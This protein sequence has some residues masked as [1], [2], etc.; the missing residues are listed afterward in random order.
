MHGAAIDQAAM[1]EACAADAGQDVRKTGMNSKPLRILL[2]APGSNPNSVTG[3]LIGFSHGNALARVH[4]VT[5]VIEARD[6]AAVLKAEGAF[7]RVEAIPPSW[8]DRFYAWAFRRVFKR[9]RGNLLFTALSFP[10][11]L[12][13]EW[14]AWRQLKKRIWQGEFDVVLRILPI[15]PMYASPFAYFLRKGP[16][17]F[18]I[19]PLNGGLPWPK[20]FSQLDRQRAAAGNWAA[21]M[22]HLYGLLPFARSTFAKA[23]AII[24]GSSHTCGEFAQY[25]EKVFYVPGENGVNASWIEERPLAGSESTSNIE[26]IYVGRLVPYKACDLALRGAAA[27]LRSGRAH[28]SILGD[29]PER[30]RFEKL[31][32]EL[33]ISAAVTFCGMATHAETLARLGRS[34]VLIFPSLREFGGG[35]VFEALAKG[36]VPIVA[37]YGGPGDIVTDQVGYRIPLTDESRMAAE[38]ESVLERLASD[39]DH[40]ETLRRR[41]TTYA[42]EHLTWEAKARQ[43]AGV[44]S[45]AV[46]AS[47]KPNMPPPERSALLDCSQDLRPV[48]QR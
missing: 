12:A 6:E 33:G 7:H 32:D 47:P 26:L 44:L 1:A 34:D 8:L 2:L 20:G 17:P 29:G 45:W 27:L 31:A 19:G 24:A 40:L 25:R 14:R 30:G 13:F 43:V 46:G 16:V 15:V 37:E 9:D 21:S 11:P 28:L 39:R 18:V 22:R 42:R 3:A 36:V 10:I 41:G 5:I 23:T 4:Q 38:I 35:V 48:S